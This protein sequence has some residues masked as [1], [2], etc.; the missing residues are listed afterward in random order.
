MTGLQR[1]P[2]RKSGDFS[3]YDM[4]K[5]QEQYNRVGIYINVGPVTSTLSVWPLGRSVYSSK[6]VIKFDTWK[7]GSYFKDKGL[8]AINANQSKEQFMYA[9]YRVFI[10]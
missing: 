7:P 3:R 4:T 10:V 9:V 8:K 1:L 5:L 6:D 2:A